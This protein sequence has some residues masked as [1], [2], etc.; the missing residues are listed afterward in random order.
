MKTVFPA[1]FIVFSLVFPVH[2][3][4]SVPKVLNYQAR[5]TDSGGVQVPDGA[6]SIIFKLYDGDGNCLYTARG[7]CGTPT[8]KSVTV[9]GSVFTT[10]IGEAADN[11]IPDGLFDNNVVT[12]GITIGADAEMTPRKRLTAAA[13]ALNADRLDDLDV[14]SS[15]STTAYIPSTTANGNLVITGDPQGTTVGTGSVYINPS[16]AAASETLFGVADNGSTRFQIDK[17]GDIAHTGS[18]LATAA[19]STAQFAFRGAASQSTNIFEVQDIF[20]SKILAVSATST[21]IGG[22]ASGYRVGIGTASPTVTL[23]VAGQASFSSTVFPVV[24]I[25]RDTPSSGSFL[26]SGAKLERLMTGQSAQDVPG[27]AFYFKSRDS[28]D[29]STWAGL[30]GGGLSTVADGAEVGFI[31]FKAAYQDNDP[32]TSQTYG[33]RLVARSTLIDDA[34]FNGHVGIGNTAPANFLT[35]GSGTST[36]EVNSSGNIAKINNVVYSWPSSQGAA[37]TVL[38]NNGSG[39]L[40]WASASGL[41]NLNQAYLSSTS[42]GQY[43]EISITPSLGAVTIADTFSGTGNIFEI[44]DRTNA[45]G[46]YSRRYFSVSSTSTLHVDGTVSSPAIAFLNE[47]NSGFYRISSGSF[48]MALSGIQTYRFSTTGMRSIDGSA[49]V[50]SLGFINDTNTGT[51]RPSNDVYSITTGGLASFYQSSTSTLINPLWNS[52]SYAVGVGTANPS[53]SLT[54]SSHSSSPDS[55]IFEVQNRTNSSGD[56]ST[57]YLTVSSTST[58]ITGGSRLIVGAT[59]TMV[60][61]SSGNFEMINGVTTRFPAAQGSSGQLLTNDGAGNLTWTTVSAASTNLNQ[62]Y[63]S[64]TSTGAYAEISITPSL[65]ALT[66]ADTLSGTGNIFEIQDRTTAAGDFSRRYLTVSSTTTAVTYNGLA[67]GDGLNVSSSGTFSG[68]LMSLNATGSATGDLLEL[69]SLAAGASARA[70]VIDLDNG[71]NERTAISLTTDE[72][73]GSTTAADTEKFSVSTA[74]TVAA[75]GNITVLGSATL[76]D[77]SGSDQ[78]VFTSGATTGSLALFQTSGSVS[79]GNVLRAASTNNTMTTGRML[80]TEHTA[81]NV[82][83]AFTGF[84]NN[85]EASRTFSTVGTYAESGSVAR[86]QRSLTS[87]GAGVT[88]NASGDV[89]L[90]NSDGTQTTGT[91]NITGNVLELAQNYAAASGAALNIVNAGTGADIALPATAIIDIGDGG[92]L[93]FRDGTNTLCTITDSGVTGSFSCTGTISGGGSNLNQ[94]YLSSTSTGEFAEIS[95]TPSLG[96]LTIADTLSGTGN[97]FE[98]QNRTTAA[99]SYSQRYFT[100]SATTVAIGPGLNT[101]TNPSFSFVDDPDTG[102]YQNVGGAIAFANDGSTSMVIEPTG[103]VVIFNSGTLTVNGGTIDIGASSGS[104]ADTPT[105][106]TFANAATSLT[107]GASGAGTTTIRTSLA[108]GNASGT[109]VANFTGARV[110]GNLTPSTDNT[111]NL[112]DYNRRWKDLWLS[113][114][115][116]HI[117]YDTSGTTSLD[118]GWI[119]RFSHPINSLRARLFSSGQPIQITPNNSETAGLYI[120]TAGRVG[121]G[122]TLPSIKLHVEDDV[123]DFVA[124]FDNNGSADTRVG[125]IIEG[126]A[127]TNPTSSCELISF[128]EGDG[129]GIGRVRGNGAGGV[130]YATTGAGDFG[131]RLPGDPS[132]LTD[133][134]LVAVGEAGAVLKATTGADL[135]GVANDNIVFAGNDSL[136]PAASVPVAMLGL[137]DAYVNVENGSIQAGDFI[138]VS[139]VPGVGMK[140]TKPGMVVGRAME[141]WNGPGQGKIQLNINTHWNSGLTITTDG[142]KSLFNDDFAFEPLAVSSA[143]GTSFSS[144]ALNFGGSTWNSASNTAITRNISIRNDIADADTYQLSFK[145]DIGGTLASLNQNGDLAIAGSLT[146]NGGFD[147]AETFPATPDLD[148]GD[149]VMV[150]AENTNGYGVKKSDAAYENTLLGVISTKPGFLTGKQDTDTQPVALAG[151]VPVKVSTESGEIKPGDPITSSSVPGV[152]MKAAEAGRVIGI[153]LQGWNEDGIGMVMVFVNPSWWNGPAA[154]AGESVGGTLS[155]TQDSLMDFKNSTLSN[156]AAIVSTNGLWS[157]SSDGYLTAER[158]DAKEV[159]TNKLTLKANSTADRVVGKAKLQA[160]YNSIIVEN[161]HVTEESVIVITFEGNP[162]SNWWIE[163]KHPGSFTMKL[164]QGAIGDTPFTYWVLPI[165]G[166]LDQTMM[167]EEEPPPEVPTESG[168]GTPPTGGSGPTESGSGTAETPPDTGS[169]TTTPETP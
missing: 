69:I 130:A 40:S 78:L 109:D 72:T 98:I 136:D 54:V 73:S 30:F 24:D 71:N 131:E 46:D 120:D 154:L 59:N 28:G 149:I 38:Q 92:T 14:T 74:G 70:I 127:D 36:F 133:G 16:N 113:G 81:P 134:Y 139:S 80:S 91:L 19:S 27:I 111:Y 55:N 161:P 117:A 76:G 169:G 155:L 114:G 85:L 6:L 62:A 128:R 163:E 121:M 4:N 132:T 37:S 165:D 104:L 105:T 31:G 1:V 157:I 142:V 152:G 17:E 151:R 34:L 90:I 167:T 65:G 144:Y 123:A 5:L 150:D 32:G 106:L 68:N 146:V 45:T 118:I 89:M 51:W 52:S 159:N 7:T 67:S 48:G 94:A 47:T 88:V 160:G 43:A 125:I 156:V 115:S 2:A 42:T 15:G 110:T 60:V 61:N 99:G 26:Y 53:A 126:C 143:S 168:T 11:E 145:N 35:V 135:I 63:L 3:A 77:S 141:S 140:A 93:I 119:S 20:T 137:A 101:A 33:L 164:A 82:T 10:H 153:A 129:S 122:T 22:S 8:A 107:I 116:A 18:L 79:T 66:I 41:V 96:A 97:V 25:Y 50:P 57:R 86:V 56:Y 13:Y 112:G 166:V 100:V 147:Y 75:D 64:S 158:V 148:A 124:Y 84:L 102:F 29:N 87:S 103:N 9:T 138:T 49:I 162:G 108:I 44:Q 58:Q 23:D 83:S 39:T 21:L 95:I 12:L